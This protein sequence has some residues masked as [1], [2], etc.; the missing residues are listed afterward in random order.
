MIHETNAKRLKELSRFTKT[1]STKATLQ[2]NSSLS[3]S[4][5][6]MDLLRACENDWM[7]LAPLRRDRLRNIRYKNGD[8]WGDTVMD[9]DGKWVR[10]EVVLSQSGKIPLKHNF[11]QQF[12]RNIEGQKLTN[13]TDSVVYA[14]C[15]DDSQLSEMLTN[16]LQACHHLNRTER[17]DTAILEEL[18]LSGIGCSK[19]RYSF[20][21]SKNRPDGRIDLVSTNRLFFN[22]DIEDP[23]LFDLR[24]IG[25]IHDYTFEELVGTFAINSADR[26][27]LAHSYA[28][29][30]M[31]GEAFQGRDLTR[32]N[33]VNTFLMPNDFTKCRVIEVWQKQGRKVTYVHDYADGSEQITSLSM[34]DI[35]TINADRIMQGMAL[36]M[37][38]QEIQLIYCEP[39]YEEFWNVKFL[40]PNGLCIREMETPYSHEEHPY[41]IATLPMVD[42]SMRGVMTD[43]IDIQRYINRLIVMIDFI[44]GSSAKGVLMIPENAIPDGMTVQDF[45]NEWVKANGVIVYKANDAGA[46]PTAI[47]SNSTNIGAWEMLNLQMSNLNKICG[48]SGAAQGQAARSNTPSSLYAQEAQNSM[49]NY[50]TVFESFKYYQQDRDEK[51]I[52]VLMQYY[53]D[54]RHI[55]ISGKSYSEVA[56]FYDPQMA[57]KIVDFNLVVSQSVNTPVFRQSVDGVLMDMLK[58]GL[59]N[60]DMFLD[61]TSMPFAEKLKAD[62]TAAKEEAMQ[63]AQGA[64][65]ATP[66]IQGATDAAQQNADP[67][68][69]AMAEQFVS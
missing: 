42:G 8:Q 29:Y 34:K 37:Q 7:R 65:A 69:V 49:I 38:E 36:G 19:T 50:V 60:M 9:T 10:E 47:S 17:I 20:W 4:T 23:R 6:N 48:L 30:G 26:E 39:R 52:K 64:Q 62:I 44:M 28:Q 12:V 35:D 67:R 33:N 63:M 32:E 45:S 56:K 55:D 54:K 2:E 13:P 51:L 46:V 22:T 15:S 16:T 53:T 1:K 5:E 59:I 61:N 40:T 11:I 43:L 58:G 41:S 24:R 31:G 25:E 18:L 68:A 3:K 66:G 57:K 21:G 27:I 14:R